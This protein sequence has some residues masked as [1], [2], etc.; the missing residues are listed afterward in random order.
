MSENS[1]NETFCRDTTLNDSEA[2]LSFHAATKLIWIQNCLIFDASL[3][4]DGK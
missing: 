3:N 1:K 2:T 4:I